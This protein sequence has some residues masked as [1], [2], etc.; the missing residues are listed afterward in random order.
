[1]VLWP[2]DGR[3]EKWR[4]KI[5]RISP[6]EKVIKGRR[7]QPEHKGTNESIKLAVGF[8]HSERLG[9]LRRVSLWPWD[10]TWQL[11]SLSDQVSFRALE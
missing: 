8:Q 4:T 5:P 6:K 11:L 1:M 9:D 7:C 10:L 3:G 2:W